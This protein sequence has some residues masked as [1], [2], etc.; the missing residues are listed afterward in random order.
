M[1]E[2][3]L[4]PESEEAEMNDFLIKLQSGV[5]TFELSQTLTKRQFTEILNPGEV[6]P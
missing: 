6:D 3:H 2:M 1:R 5:H 4:L